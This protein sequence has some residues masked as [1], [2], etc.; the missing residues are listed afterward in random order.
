M[1]SILSITLTGHFRDLLVS[2]R[3]GCSLSQLPPNFPLFTS[4]LPPFLGM[5]F[6][7]LL[8]YV[9]SSS[10]F[11]SVSLSISH[12]LIL[13]H[14][15]SPSLSFSLSFF[16]SHSPTHYL[17]FSFS[18][19]LSP[20]PHLWLFFQLSTREKDFVIDTLSLRAQ[21][22]LLGEIFANPSVVKIM[23]GNERF[24]LNMLV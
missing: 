8:I 3:S 24:T 1:E 14:S 22:F 9:P 18:L 20:S 10:P 11:F 5:T 7:H 21:M 19:Y 16:L 15:P 6:S 2:C 17:S 23:H 13:S 4:S 12:S